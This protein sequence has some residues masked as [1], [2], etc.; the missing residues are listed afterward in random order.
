MKSLDLNDS[1]VEKFYYPISKQTAAERIK[2]QK[3]FYDC[4]R[5][6]IAND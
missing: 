1:A 2:V 4:L 5:R 6:Q 3:D